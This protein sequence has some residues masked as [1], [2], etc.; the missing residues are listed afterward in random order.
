[1][2]WME[3]IR[4]RGFD[5]VYKYPISIKCHGGHIFQLKDDVPA[6]SAGGTPIMAVDG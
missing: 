6:A 3:G 5:A 4:K 1:M 2:G